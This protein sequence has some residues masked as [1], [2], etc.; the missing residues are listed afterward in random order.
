MIIKKQFKVT[1]YDHKYW[2]ILYIPDNLVGKVPIVIFYHGTGETGST[3]SS[4]DRL[5]NNGPLNFIRS[6]W[7]PNFMVLAMQSASWSPTAKSGDFVT[8]ND[9]DITQR[10]NGKAL[11]TGLSAG[12]S[13]TYGFMNE[14][15]NT[16]FS[17]IPM[18]PA[19]DGKLIS[20]EKPWKLW[21]FA[22]DSDGLFTNNAKLL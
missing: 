12:G 6:G 9:P 13:A 2:G 8:K 15:A 21:A 16:N 11:I 22:G 18:S 5:Y 17:Y 1:Q 7:R 14:I 19:G 3:E 4:A 10:W 20:P